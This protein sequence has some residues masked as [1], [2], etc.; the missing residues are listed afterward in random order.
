[1]D[2]MFD[3]FSLIHEVDIPKDSRNN[4][5]NKYDSKN[6]F[7]QHYNSNNNLNNFFFEEKKEKNDDK[8]IIEEEKKYNNKRFININEENYSKSNIENVSN[9][10]FL[11]NYFENKVLT[12]Q[13]I[14]NSEI[15]FDCLNKF[16]ECP[17]CEGFFEI[18]YF[19]EKHENFCGFLNQLYD[20]KKDLIECTLCNSMINRNDH[21][22]HK[23]IC[24]GNNEI[25]QTFKLDCS[26]CN[27][28]FPF[29]M[30][31]QHEIL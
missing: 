6:S 22:D 21:S 26:F 12:N 28:S 17:I 2:E 14:N 19:Y 24:Q 9:N 18:A 20:E 5:N 25:A 11:N 10:I 23:K 3:P 8:M 7:P 13:T 16:I 31:E 29:E 27:L 30:I 15:C 4:V 1:M